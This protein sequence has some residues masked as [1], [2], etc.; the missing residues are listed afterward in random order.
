M[1]G[2]DGKKYEPKTLMF[3]FY[4]FWLD[5]LLRTINLKL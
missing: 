4:F 3:L 1:E 5:I 2:Y